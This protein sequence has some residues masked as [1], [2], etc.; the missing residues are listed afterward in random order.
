MR[1]G[2]ERPL[3]ISGFLLFYEFG[4][5]VVLRMLDDEFT[6][7]EPLLLARFAA[8]ATLRLQHIQTA[9][10]AVSA[11]SIDPA[12]LGYIL[13]NSQ[14]LKNGA[15]VIGYQRFHNLLKDVQSVSNDLLAG[16]VQPSAA[17]HDALTEACRVLQS[18]LLAY[19]DERL[20]RVPFSRGDAQ[21]AELLS[22]IEI[23]CN[24]Q[25]NDSEKRMR[26]DG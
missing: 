22:R 3:L 16:V 19:R 7:T 12:L 4:T 11:V 15:L 1:G 14:K 23:I 5:F 18:L 21:D 24:T 17:V 26:S 13:A 2:N 6:V 8:G 10:E 9:I 20:T 25:L